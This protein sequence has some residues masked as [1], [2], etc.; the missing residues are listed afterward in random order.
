M[1]LHVIGN[2]G[3]V[4]YLGA[5]WLVS[6]GRVASFSPRYQVPNFIGALI[7]LGY[8][9]ILTAWASVVLNVVWALI[10]GTS[11]VINAKGAR[12]TKSQTTEHG[13]RA[14]WRS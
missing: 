8:S 14:N 12:A 11:L 7:L 2:L 3:V 4:L 9:I 1:L 5:Y 6:L 10:A 13:A